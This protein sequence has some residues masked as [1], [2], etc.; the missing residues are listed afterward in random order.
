M[1]VNVALTIDISDSE[2]KR[3]KRLLLFVAIFKVIRGLWNLDLSGSVDI[4]IDKAKGK[5]NG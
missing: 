2:P 1:K 4:V 5:E 3:W